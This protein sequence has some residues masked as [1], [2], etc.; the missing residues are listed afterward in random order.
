MTTGKDINVPTRITHKCPAC[1]RPIKD[2]QEYCPMCEI[3]IARKR[4]AQH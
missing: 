1:L 2:D 3:K 4:E